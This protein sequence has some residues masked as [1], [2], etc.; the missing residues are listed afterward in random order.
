MSTLIAIISGISPTIADKFNNDNT[1]SSTERGG[2]HGT[3]D[4]ITI[5]EVET[6]IPEF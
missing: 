4:N 1:T 3:T 6:G 5:S 2:T